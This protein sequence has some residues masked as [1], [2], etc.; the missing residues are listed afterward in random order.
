MTCSSIPPYQKLLLAFL[1]STK[2]RYETC[3]MK[4]WGHIMRERYRPVDMLPYYKIVCVAVDGMSLFELL[5][6]LFCVCNF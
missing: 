4:G 6:L 1:A 5:L 3:L 2:D